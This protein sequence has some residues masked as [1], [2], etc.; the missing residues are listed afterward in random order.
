MNTI[1]MPRFVRAS[2]YFRPFIYTS[3][4]CGIQLVYSLPAVSYSSSI[5]GVAR[6]HIA[7]D[8]VPPERTPSMGEFGCRGEGF[9]V[10]SSLI[11]LIQSSF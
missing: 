11:S 1:F 2:R 3:L 6:A 5:Y 7:H 9:V 4:A 10:S 8:H